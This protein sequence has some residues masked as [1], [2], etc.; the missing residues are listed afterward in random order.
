MALTIAQYVLDF[1]LDDPVFADI[2]NWDGTGYKPVFPV[3][4]QP[5]SDAPYV[6]WTSRDRGIGTDWWMEETDVVMAFY[7]HDLENSLAATNRIKYL[8]RRKDDSARDLRVWAAAN[9]LEAYDIHSVSYLGG[10]NAEETDQEGGTH[11]R[12]ASI[13]VSYSTREAAGVVA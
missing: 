6:V 3:Q 5:E 8:F 1:L 13:S 7:D 12:M 10:G 9:G 11:M 4:S 2:V